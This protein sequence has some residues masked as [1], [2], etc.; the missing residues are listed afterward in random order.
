[1]FEIMGKRGLPLSLETIGNY[2]ANILGAPLGDTWPR[3]FKDRHNDSLRIKLTHSLEI[4]RAQA[5][6]PTAIHDDRLRYIAKLAGIELEKNYAQMVL[7]DNEN[8]RLRKQVFAK[9]TKKKQTYTTGQARLLTA[10][11]MQAALLRADHIKSMK[12]VIKEMGPKLQLGHVGAGLGLN[13][14]GVGVDA[15]TG[16]P[17]I[18]QMRITRHLL[19]GKGMLMLMVVVADDDEE[20]SHGDE[21]GSD[22]E[23]DFNEEKSDAP[24]GPE[25]SPSRSPSPSGSPTPSTGNADRDENTESDGE[26]T[27]ISSINGHRWYQG[28]VEFQ[29]LWSDEDATWEPLSNVNDCVAMEVYLAHRDVADPIRLPKRKYLIDKAVKASN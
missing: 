26:E 9:K 29:V 21:E 28:N 8:E 23:E 11:E 14:W 24:S 5:L 16:K 2:V 4:C 13:A 10:P 19:E 27:Q 15:D 7:M 22:D 25:S 1:M 18:I 20:D 3:C 17:L 12:V 6:N